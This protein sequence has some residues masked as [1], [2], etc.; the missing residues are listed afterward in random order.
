MGNE[1]ITTNRTDL[2][3]MPI[4][5][6]TN[7]FYDFCYC[8]GLS[9]IGFPC[10][11]NERVNYENFHSILEDYLKARSLFIPTT[12]ILEFVSK[13]RNDDTHLKAIIS[14][15]QDISSRYSYN[16]FNFEV[17][18]AYFDFYPDRDWVKNMWDII[19]NDYSKLYTHK[20]ELG[21]I[22]IDSEAEIICLFSRI[23]SHTFLSTI[24][25]NLEEFKEAVS[26]FNHMVLET[27]FGDS[28]QKRSKKH[29]ARE[30]YGYYNDNKEGK[31][32]VKICDYAL[33]NSLTMLRIYFDFLNKEVLHN[34]DS[35]FD[36]IFDKEPVEYAHYIQKQYH[37][38]SSISASDVVS[39]FT[40]GPG[41]S[42][43]QLDYIFKLVTDLFVD[44][45][46]TEKNDSE[47]FWNLIFVSG[48]S[49]LITF[50]LELIETIK[51]TNPANY[52]LIT[53]FYNVGLL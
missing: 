5:L 22:K 28:I 18:G 27:P 43:S 49:F 9:D 40:Y 19:R 17:P 52:Q 25:S 41:F 33:D 6:D 15:L 30:L 12:T 48:N 35:P 42:N 11:I 47:D 50:E 4:F 44:G 2:S 51:D 34:N 32:K 21:L 7:A 46:K 13:F 29:I 1:R 31:N 26:S 37:K 10:G 38:N 14:F 3:C 24:H 23:I 16:L 20:D 45:A 36:S 39:S 8:F 53:S